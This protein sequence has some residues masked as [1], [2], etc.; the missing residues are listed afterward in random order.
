MNKADKETFAAAKPYVVGII[1]LVF[2]LRF[3]AWSIQSCFNEAE[4][5]VKEFENRNP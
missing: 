3:T 4:K 5:F 1:A 2:Q